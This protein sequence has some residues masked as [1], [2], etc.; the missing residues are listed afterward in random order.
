MYHVVAFIYAI[1]NQTTLKHQNKLLKSLLILHFMRRVEII[2]S[3]QENLHLA[4][5]NCKIIDITFNEL[6]ILI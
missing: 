3:S 2:C 6:Y 4:P 1:F 5:N